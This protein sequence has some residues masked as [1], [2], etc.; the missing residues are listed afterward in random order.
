LR[1]AI[2][3]VLSP[4]E[5][6]ARHL[7]EG[8]RRGAWQGTMPGAPLLAAELG[9][10]PKTADAA[11]RLLEARGL[12]VPQGAGR[13]RRIAL[14]E[15][16]AEARPLRIGILLSD[17]T[18]KRL[19]Y[20]SEIQHDLVEAGHHAFFTEKN[21]LDLGMNLPRIR[22]LVEGAKADA[23]IVTAGSREVLHWFGEQKK[24]AFALF[25]RMSGVSVA[26][27]RPDKVPPYEAAVARLVETGHRR[28]VLL[29]RKVRRLPEPG[30]SERAFL[31]ALESH[32]IATGP[33]HLPDWK[34]DMAGFHELLDRLFRFTPPTALIIQEAFL[35]TATYH[36]LAQRGLRVPQDVSLV[37]TDDDSSFVWSD[38]AVSH[39]RWDSRPMVRRIV[40]WAA[41]VGN[42]QADL[43]QT[44][45]N[46][47]F[48]EGGTLGPANQPAGTAQPDF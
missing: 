3:T 13:R 6:V 1:M 14:P 30:R 29:A 37:C 44:M 47:E 45:T 23:W 39:I 20:V 46:A 34:D 48:V 17:P 10:D 5:Q 12:L 26:G 11:L 35:F 4:G 24:P 9:I 16:A 40:G 19:D 21:L 7:E 27:T 8:L 18:A 28:I 15:G 38:P 36:Y 32:G 43:R 22:K 41:K 2:L 31:Q 25:G 42:G 33:Y